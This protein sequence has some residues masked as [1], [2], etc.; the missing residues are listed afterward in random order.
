MAKAPDDRYL[1]AGDLGAAAVAAAS[2]AA[3]SRAEHSVAAGAAS[4]TGATAVA[5]RAGATGSVAVGPAS[6]DVVAAEGRPTVGAVSIDRPR[7]RTWWLVGAGGLVAIVVVVLAIALSGGGGGGRA[8]SRGGGTTT[9]GGS[10]GASASSP[11]AVARAWVAAYNAGDFVKG[12]S[13]FKPGANVNGSTFTSQ[14][15]FV[16]FQ[17]AYKCALRLRS[18]SVRGSVVRIRGQRSRTRPCMQW[19]RRDDRRDCAAHQ[20][21]ADH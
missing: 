17:A 3:L 15:Q 14:D 19:L 21:R 16:R 6:E 1:S 20:A 8:T 12:A 5:E 9:A 7:H 13:Y 10:G 4:P 11:E 18:L 2:G